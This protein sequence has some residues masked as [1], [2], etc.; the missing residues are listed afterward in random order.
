ME[1]VKTE[2]LKNFQLF[3]LVREE[4]RVAGGGLMIGV[5][6]ELKSMQVRQGNNKV[7]CLVLC[8]FYLLYLNVDI[9]G[10]L[11]I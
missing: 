2:Y 9:V 3:K 11:T 7:E 4:E 5:D 10:K 8:N 1:N 6:R